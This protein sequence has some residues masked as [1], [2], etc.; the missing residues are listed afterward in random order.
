MV[1]FSRNNNRK[2]LFCDHLDT[3]RPYFYK[4]L[5]KKKSVVLITTTISG[6]F[7]IYVHSLRRL[8]FTELLVFLEYYIKGQFL[9]FQSK[10]K[11]KGY[12]T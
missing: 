2:I 12:I 4:P 8:G 1:L 6:Q 3:D 9:T 5:K 11:L 7:R 10:E